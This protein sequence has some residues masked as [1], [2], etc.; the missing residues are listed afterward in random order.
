MRN[1][2]TDLIS[3][4]SAY[5][6]SS[7]TALL[8]KKCTTTTSLRKARQLHA[9][10]VTYATL[11]VQ[12]PYAHNNLL[13][14]Y[15]RC[16]SLGDSQLLFDIM[17]QRSIVSYNT[18]IAAYSR[19]AYHANLS[20]KLLTQMETEDLRPN[21]STFTSLLQG[22]SSLE[23]QFIGSELHA[24]VVK[25]GF[26]NDVCVQTSALGM[27]SNCGDQESAEKMFGDIVDKDAIAWNSV[28]FGNLKNERIRKGLHVFGSM[29]RHGVIPT[30]YTYSMV[31]NACSRLGN[32]DFGRTIHAR[33]IVFDIMADLPLQ[34]ALVDMYCCGGNVQTAFAIFCRIENPDLVSWNSIIAGYAKKGDGEEAI[35]MFVRLLRMSFVEPDEHT[36]AAIISATGGLAASDYGKPL[37]ALVT[38]AGFQSSV[39][40]GSTLVSMYFKN[41][42][43]D[44]AQKVFSLIPEK[45]VVLWTEMITAHSRMGDGETAVKLFHEMRQDCHKIDSFVLSG[46]LSACADLAILK[47]GEMIHSLAL[48]SG[49]DVEMSV[50]GSL[51]DM[52]AKSGNLQA[53][54]SIFSLVE[55]PD[56]KCWNSMLGGYSHHGRAEEGLKLFDEI[57][58]HDKRP[59]HVTFVSLLAACSN[60]GLVKQG[61]LLWSQMKEM[62]IMPGPKHYSCMVSLLSRAGLLEE[63]E[64]IIKESP[65]GEDFLD[66]WRTLLSSCISTKN[67]RTGV[68]AAEQVLSL[69]AEDGATLT[70]LSNLYAAA[71]KWDMVAEIRMKIRGLMLE[72]DPGLSWV[73]EMTGIQVF[74]SGDQSHPRIDE[75]QQELLRLHRN[76][77]RS[78]MDEFL[79]TI[80]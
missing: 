55:N 30:Q 16:G 17:P 42:E 48:R 60:C 79:I 61:K 8:I 59:D 49:C 43:T 35:D 39:Y 22:S 15:G 12:S 74:A 37:H 28:I 21:G 52:Y 77:V 65:F 44:S 7:L 13:S 72:K 64:E 54:Q 66:L 14:M 53:A 46:V 67:L 31:L 73:E 34:N 50:C 75:A 40:I 38:K 11:S 4:P 5:E 23:D 62:S 32:H 10:M 18:L 51:V 36:F 25:F 45:D 33:L 29:V 24:Q 1:K 3:M 58:N 26:L 19:T 68:H 63:A 69:D 27:Y 78:E 41:Y 56:L 70:L 71:G 57:L 80:A 20:F 6:A 47:Q 76:I 2:P 9:L